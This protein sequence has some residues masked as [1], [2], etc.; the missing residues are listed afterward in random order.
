MKV[1]KKICLILTAL[2]VMM[3]GCFI[4]ADRV[5]A[6]SAAL[7]GPDEI[8]IGESFTVTLKVSSPGSVALMGDIVYNGA[9]L[10]LQSSECVFGDWS[11]DMTG[12]HFAASSNTLSNEL[13]NTEAVMRFTFAVKSD[14]PKGTNLT[15]SATN[16]LAQG[17]ADVVIED[18]S[19]TKAAT[20]TL[21]ENADLSQ[22]SVNGLSLTPGFS[23]ETT[24]YILGEV[25]YDVEELTVNAA[26]ADLGA[27]VEITGEKLGVGSNIISVKVTAEKGNTKTY[28][29]TVTRKPEQAAQEP[30]QSPTETQSAPTEKPAETQ[31]E[32]SGDRNQE[33]PSQEEEGTLSRDSLI[34]I[35]LILFVVFG[36]GAG[37][38]IYIYQDM[39]MQDKKANT[40]LKS[41]TEKREPES[42]DFNDDLDF[43]EEL[44]EAEEVDAEYA[45]IGGSSRHRSS[46]VKQVIDDEEFIRRLSESMKKK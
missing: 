42:N 36:G 14:V 11:S 21:S 27:K 38:G 24:S 10:E 40:F 29:L 19:Y 35:A 33:K 16:L 37:L 8:K 43:I 5:K 12:N 18:V 26:T 3:L 17:E 45:Q 22:L 20:K 9:Y 28:T 13:T 6:A 34:I 39:K 1:K 4:H 2:A 25:E 32:A 15:V 41:K 30:S 31:T 7:S 23:R 46:D 44:S